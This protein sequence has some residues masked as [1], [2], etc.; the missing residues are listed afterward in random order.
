M[1][2]SILLLGYSS[3]AS[4]RVIPAVRR[5]F[6]EQAVDVASKSLREKVG[7]SIGS[8]FG[9]YNEALAKS[10][11]ETVYI[12][13]PNSMHFKFASMALE[14]GRHVIID[15]PALKTMRETEQLVEKADKCGRLIS[16]ATV[17]NYHQQ[18]RE[19]DAFFKEHGPLQCVS[20]Q[21]IIP[22]MPVENFRNH[23]ALG[24]GCLL[25][26][27]PYLAALVRL[28]AGAGSYELHA[29]SGPL[30]HQTG[31]DVGF[32]ALVKGDNNVRIS[33][34]FGFHGEY[35]NRIILIG[36]K[37]SLECS[38]IFSPPPDFKPSWRVRIASHE[39]AREVSADDTFRRFLETVFASI[40]NSD[41][42]SFA[43]T[44]LVD[45]QFRDRL[46]AQVGQ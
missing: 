19:I 5:I 28:F 17:F 3:I 20:A 33:G 6:P 1:T 26:M 22:P 4:R 9:D 38:R 34:H 2:A 35:Q 36:E 37:G 8:L 44:M 45:A 23:R 42:F 40:N 24:G 46:T 14:S 27:G 39:S 11:A 31:V 12:S 10:D 21:F 41:H 7:E 29:L 13:L 30:N 43:R 32:S 15:K 18:F 25:D 16:E